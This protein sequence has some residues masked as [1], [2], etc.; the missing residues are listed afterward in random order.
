M[1]CPLLLLRNGSC[2]TGQELC[3]LI[4][5]PLNYKLFHS[6]DFGCCCNCMR[7]FLSIFPPARTRSL[8]TTFL[9]GKIICEKCGFFACVPC[10]SNATSSVE[11]TSHLFRKHMEHCYVC[12]CMC[13]RLRNSQI[14]TDFFHAFLLI[15]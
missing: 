11:I 15:G 12:L 8:G 10:V 14:Q 6:L 4:T 2:S 3:E 9:N 13:A 5:N 7:V 1:I